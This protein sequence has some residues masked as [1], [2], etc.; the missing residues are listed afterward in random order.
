MS[1]TS[2]GRLVLVSTI[3]PLTFCLSA[4]AQIVPDNT[5][6]VSSS[7]A[8]GCVRC[9]I[10]GGTVR[11][12]N[13]FHSLREFSIPTGG[14]AW[15]NNGPTI[16][17]ILTRVT[18]NSI[19]N[20]D[21]LLKTNGTAS[22]FLLNPNGISFGANAR[23]E[24]GGSF[25]ASTASS[26]RFA[27]GTEFSATNPQA[28]PLLAVNLT[29][30]L[31][32]GPK[33]SGSI[34]NAGSLSAG[35]DLALV[36]GDVN[37]SGL[38]AAP[39]G[40]VWVAA[41]AGDATV[42]RAIGQ[43]VLLAADRNLILEK[44]QLGAIGDLTLLAGDT[45]RVRDSV[46][47]PFVAWAGGNLT[48]MGQQGIDI[49]ALNHPG[50]A[51]QSGGSLSLISN[52]VVSGDAHFASGGRFQVLTLA[53]Q[54]GKFVSL[55][56]PII[57]SYSDVVLGDYTGTSLKVETLGNITIGTIAITGPDT[58]LV[59]SDPDIATLRNGSAVIL[60]AGLT[61][62][63]NPPNFGADTYRITNLGTL[64]GRGDS[65]F[66]YGINEAGQVV[67]GVGPSQLMFNGIAPSAVTAIGSQAFLYT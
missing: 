1:T 61:T 67:G 20:I 16:Q 13:L 21:G 18:G 10:E 40:Q 59:G 14:A 8:P 23:L 46:T 63:D 53:G 27:D 62:L 5:L 15:F 17:T 44:S 7:V 41:V 19:S 55:H 25:L 3:A 49:L 58:S 2:I 47:E 64:P 50:A 54:P 33:P 28:P 6:P 30:G 29:P 56:D 9:T 36:S 52:G 60:R 39:H 34:T 22:L 42:Q 38:L 24:I 32:F 4:Q 57:S 65:S 48:V 51:F 66:A 45:V 11:G 26:F 31:Q 43:N 37:S 35:Q 12:A